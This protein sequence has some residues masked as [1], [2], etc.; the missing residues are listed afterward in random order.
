MAIF[1]TETADAQRGLPA[2]NT[3]ARVP[4]PKRTGDL[5]YR[6]VTYTIPA[7]G[8]P[9]TADL[10]YLSAM[11]RNAYLVTGLCKIYC[12]DPGTSFNIAKIGDLTQTG[13]TIPSDDLDD[14]DRYSNAID[15]SAGGRFEFNDAGRP[16]ALAGYMVT[17]PQW[18]IATLGTI[19]TLTAG[20][21][22][23]FVLVFAGQS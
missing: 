19:S 1:Y 23:R 8:A 22:I 12:A 21:T 17:R 15:L 14:D 13:E 16:G 18:L 11:P 10:L 9:V 4:G 6:E 2:A 5:M 3:W 20:V 7:T